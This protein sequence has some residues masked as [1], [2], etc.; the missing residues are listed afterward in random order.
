MQTRASPVLVNILATA[1][2][3]KPPLNSR[4]ASNRS[5]L[6][7]SKPSPINTRQGERFGAVKAHKD[8]TQPPSLHHLQIHFRDPNSTLNK[9]Q[10]VIVIYR[11]RQPVLILN[12]PTLRFRFMTT[13]SALRFAE[14]HSV[15]LRYEAVHVAA[16]VTRARQFHSCLRRSTTRL[17]SWSSWKGQSPTSCLPRCVSEMPRLRINPPTH[18]SASPARSLP[19]RSASSF[20]SLRRFSK[21]LSRQFPGKLL[22]PT[23]P[24]HTSLLCTTGK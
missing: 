7:C 17:G 1:Q 11:P 18:F 14:V 15:S 2:P 9:V 6:P 21:K 10:R 12:H 19:C 13:K 24:R 4:A 16:L 5:W 23:F 8:L 20:V 22:L 3:S